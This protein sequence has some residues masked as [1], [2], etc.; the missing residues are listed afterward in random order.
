MVPN[1][2]LVSIGLVLLVAAGCSDK[3]KGAGAKI[4]VSIP[5]I[6]ATAV[7]DYVTVDSKSVEDEGGVGVLTINLTVANLPEGKSL[8]VQWMEVPGQTTMV[9]P[10][11][12]DDSG[13]AVVKVFMTARNPSSSVVLALLE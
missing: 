5:T 6:D 11:E 12:P 7:T 4:D 13:K 10:V 8:V 2:M 1:W 9:Q 3:Q